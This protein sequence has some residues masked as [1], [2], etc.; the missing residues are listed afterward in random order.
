MLLEILDSSDEEQLSILIVLLLELLE[1]LLMLMEELLMML[2]AE[3]LLIE[4]L[5]LYFIFFFLSI[6]SDATLLRLR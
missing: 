3:L 2:I 6:G 5:E 4:L 1:L